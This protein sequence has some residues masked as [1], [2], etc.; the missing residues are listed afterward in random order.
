M[1]D[2]KQGRDTAATRRKPALPRWFLLLLSMTVWPLLIFLCHGVLPWA[3]SGMARRFGWTS[4]SP[5]GWNWPGLVFVGFG[6]IGV[7]WFW[8][9]H[10]RK[11]IA[12][13]K[14]VLQFT[15]DYLVTDGPYR[16]SR[17]PM[18]LAV[19]IIWFGWAVFFGSLLVLAGSFFGWLLLNFVVIPREERGLAARHGEHYRSY[20]KRVPRWF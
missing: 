4:G 10:M 12:V 9:V 13:E 17:N 16:Y 18:Y 3:L 19:L 2:S 14:V 8:F 15:P 11:V 7:L 5:G 1:Q 20:V 6:T